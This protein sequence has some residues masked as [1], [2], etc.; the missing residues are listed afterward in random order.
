MQHDIVP[1]PGLS[2]PGLPPEHPLP[3]GLR[4]RF[5]WAFRWEAVLALIVVLIVAGGTAASPEFLTSYNL[6][7]LGLSNGEIAMMALPMTLIV[8]SGEIDLSVASTLGMSSCLL[9]FL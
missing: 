5:P 1:T 7:N 9:G 6:F 2:E 8:I 3:V 4:E